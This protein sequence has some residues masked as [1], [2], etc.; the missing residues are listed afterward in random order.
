[1]ASE[2]S[3]VVR[4]KDEASKVFDNVK[5]AGQGAARSLE[6]SWKEISVVAGGAALAIEGLARSQAP[7]NEST[8][9]LA[10]SIGVTEGEM[11]DLIKSTSDVTFPLSDVAAVMESGRQQ[12]IKST[13]QLQDFALFW[14][15]VGD[16]TGLAADA[17]ADGGVALRT[18]GIAAGDES[19]AIAAFGFIT[20]ETTSD[21]GEFLQII[22]RV[23]PELNDM[24]VDIDQTAGLLGI[25][26]TEMGLT[27]RMARRELE[28]GIR[29]A[30]GSLEDLLATLGITGEQFEEYTK[31]VGESSEVIDRNADLHADSYTQLQKFQHRIG[32]VTF[33]MGGYIQQAAQVAPLMMAIGPSIKLVSLAKGGLATASKIA[34]V[35]VGGLSKA[36][37]ILTGPV[38]LAIAAI[39]AAVAIGWYLWK[40][41]DEVVTFVTRLWQDFSAWFGGL[42]QGIRDRWQESVDH[43]L[44][45]ARAL[46]EGVVDAWQ[47]LVDGIKGPAN[48]IIGI[49]NSVIGAFERM[50]NG[51]GNA[52]NSIPSISIPSWV[53]VIGGR[54]FSLPN[55][56]TVNL[57]RIP[58][59]SSGGDV[60]RGGLALVGER[61]AEVVDLPTGSRVHPHGA[62]GGLV[63]HNLTINANDY[64]G[65]QR[66]GRGFVDEVRRLG[67]KLTEART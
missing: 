49:A 53:P 21:V 25:L 37:V 33:S 40:N 48:A 51:V 35:A 4:A 10:A 57:A 63:V 7:L 58:G 23:G 16:A 2:M 56:P 18:I 6:S 34:A 52:V 14:D 38:G 43:V 60:T 47:S 28:Q 27:G 29:E 54:S 13:E 41:W 24:G 26:E 5:G 39:V 64:E 32:E 31:R 11:R 22:E 67:F 9:R 8:R 44:D 20:E 59:L 30:D 3:L 50:L 1:M 17:L 46:R 61:G 62:G 42:V 36:M 65:G 45:I 15:K 55:I 12:G 19:E 66:A